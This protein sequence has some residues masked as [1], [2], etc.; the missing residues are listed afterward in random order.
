MDLLKGYLKAVESYLPH[1]QPQ[2]IIRELEE[3]IQ[4]QMDEQAESLGR[5][6]TEAEQAA[7]LKRIG[8]PA[9][10]A[11]RYHTSELSVA[12][13]RQLIGPGLFPLYTRVLSIA[14]VGLVVVWVLVMLAL[15]RPVLSEGLGVL[16]PLVIQFVIITAIFAG[17]QW[18]LTQHPDLWNAWNPMEPPVRAPKFHAPR[19]EALIEFIVI[20]A[21]LQVMRSAELLTVRDELA[22]LLPPVWI[23]LYGLVVAMTAA[24]LVPPL[25]GLVQ[26]RWEQL[27]Q[28]VRFGLG[29]VWLGGLAYLLAA[30]D[31]SMSTN[32]QFGQYAWYN[33]LILAL[34]SAVVVAFDGLAFWRSRRRPAATP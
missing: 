11:G 29:L 33:I 17:L 27:R 24:G 31:W 32:S 1:E 10:V 15:G 19:L 23:P 34:I 3:N 6:L 13:G 20:A 28:A 21:V 26:P 7:I 18:H 14:A 22:R 12:F 16:Q 2:D 5:P 4:A 9:L 30:G 25:I 8:N